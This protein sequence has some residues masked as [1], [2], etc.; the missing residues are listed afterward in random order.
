MFK[1]PFISCVRISL[2]SRIIEIICDIIFLCF[3]IYLYS[4]AITNSCFDTT[5][6]IY[7][8]TNNLSLTDSQQ[9]KSQTCLKEMCSFSTIK[10][11]YNII[12]ERESL[13]Y[14]LISGNYSDVSKIPN[15]HFVFEDNIWWLVL[16]TT[17]FIN[18]VYKI[19]YTI[20]YVC[21]RYDKIT[22]ELYESFIYK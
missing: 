9:C 16:M 17:M 21:S 22:G 1:L 7:G 2:I 8:K 19:I 5:Y 15:L 6:K 18:I 10:D 11:I 14:K 4:G 12:I 20:V 3:V 13:A